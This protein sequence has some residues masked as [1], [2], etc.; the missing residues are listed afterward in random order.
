M[1]A[2][3]IFGVIED[4]VT[5]CGNLCLVVILVALW[6]ILIFILGQPCVVS[7]ESVLKD[8]KGIAWEACTVQGLSIAQPDVALA[9][10]DGIG[11]AEAPAAQLLDDEL[12]GGVF[13]LGRIGVVLYSHLVTAVASTTDSDE[14]LFA[15]LAK[16]HLIVLCHA[17]TL[18]AGSG[19]NLML[20]VGGEQYA[21][22]SS[23][24][25]VGVHGNGGTPQFAI[26]TGDD[27]D[28]FLVIVNVL[29][30][31]EHGQPPNG[32][33]AKFFCAAVA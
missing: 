30:A 6:F 31:V 17:E 28:D 25:G 1:S 33:C 22:G 23:G 3:S 20:V 21:A 19:I 13:T 2:E 12:G 14:F 18:V 16:I 11:G 5:L 4:G 26:G 8:G 9:V 29:L 15:F 7:A 27:G 10:D 32:K 24:G